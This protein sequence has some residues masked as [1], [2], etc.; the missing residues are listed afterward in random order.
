MRLLFMGTPT[1]VIPVLEALRTAGDIDLV[2]VYTTPDR[3]KGRGRPQEMSPV[4]SYSLS[5]GLPV[6]QPTSLRSARVQTELAALHPD[7][8][9]VAAYGKFLPTEVLHTP[10]HG[11]LNLHPSLLP[12]YRGPSPVVTAILERES[13]TGITLMLLNEGMDTGSLIAQRTHPISSKDTAETLTA[14]LFQLGAELLLENLGPW[15]SGQLQPQPQDE[16]KATVTRKLERPDGLVSWD[17]SAVELE[18]RRRAYTPW[19]G[20]FTHW[21]GQVLKLLDV[22]ALPGDTPLTPVS[23]ADPP[24]S[25]LTKRG[26]QGGGEPAPG[27]VVPLP[28]RDTPVGVGTGQGILGLKLVQ[29]EGRRAVTAGEFLRGYPEF[30]YSQL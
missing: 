25:P 6:Y 12:R 18:R 24:V 26:V 22:V 21:K 4:K 3:P 16:T 14:T 27:L 13:V 5:Q 7:V 28:L 2:G 9:V 1:F 8:I 29:L 20:L 10:P 11:C 30:L 23:E 19:P 15:V 17:L